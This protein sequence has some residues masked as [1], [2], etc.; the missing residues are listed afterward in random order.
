[1]LT[2]LARGTQDLLLRFKK[3]LWATR[4]IQPHVEIIT[5]TRE[6][7]DPALCLFMFRQMWVHVSKCVILVYKRSTRSYTVP[8]YVQADV[9]SC[10][11][12][13]HTCVQEK[14]KI[15]HCASLC[16]GRCGFTCPNVSYLWTRE[17]QDPNRNA[18]VVHI[19]LPPLHIGNPM[20][21]AE[22]TR[23][24][25]KLYAIQVWYSC[26]VKLTCCWTAAWLLV[27]ENLSCKSFISVT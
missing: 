14:H 3:L 21:R 22:S 18:Q 10:V 19:G 6:T 26:W 5:V 9:G 1:M 2:L 20:Y 15:L 11:Q 23:L 24:K 16:S 25:L 8:L 12:M 27:T 13:C 4:W 7:Q 17:A